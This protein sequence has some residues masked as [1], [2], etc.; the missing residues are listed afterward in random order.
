ML[1]ISMGTTLSSGKVQNG[2]NEWGDV[3]RL[4]LQLSWSMYLMVLVDDGFF[5]CQERI[6]QYQGSQEQPTS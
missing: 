6:L 2:T 5:M 3:I 1:S 4:N